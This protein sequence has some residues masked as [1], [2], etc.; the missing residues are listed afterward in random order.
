[1]LKGVL[2]HDIVWC[3]TLRY[4]TISF[5]RF[6]SNLLCCAGSLLVV[7]DVVVVAFLVGTFVLSFYIR[8]H[9]VVH[10]VQTNVATTNK[11]MFI[12]CIRKIYRPV[13][14]TFRKLQVFS[15]ISLL[16]SMQEI[17]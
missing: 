8:T 14:L 9:L 17:N 16:F 2:C 6:T 15:I 1:M 5:I 10:R 4:G 12:V 13:W 11:R 7:A 3:G